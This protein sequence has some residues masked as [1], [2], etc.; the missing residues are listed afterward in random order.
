MGYRKYYNIKTKTSDGIVFDSQKE[1]LRWEQLRILERQVAY[2]I[3]PAQY[4][5]YDRYSKTGKRLKD[6]QR[7]V[8]RKVEYVADFVYTDAQTGER[9]VEDAKGVRTKDYII[10][11]KLMHA[12][13]GIKIHE[14]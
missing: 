8:E 14:T 2:E 9:I 4:E 6:G 1:A 12:V 13:H 3:I 11:R 7:L 5:T 10:K